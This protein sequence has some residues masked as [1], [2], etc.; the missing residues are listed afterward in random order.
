MNKKLIIFILLAVLFFTMGCAS[1]V[2]TLPTATPGADGVIDVAGTM[3]MAQMNAN[4]AQQAVG[5]S[6]TAT[7]Q[8]IMVTVTAQAREDGLATAEQ[9]RRD[10]AAT[11]AKEQAWAVATDQQHRQDVAATQARIDADATAQQAERNMIGTATAQQQTFYNNMTM[12]VQPTHAIWTQ[13]AVVVAQALATNE[14]ALSNLEVEQ[15]S[16]KNTPEW[17]IPLLIAIAATVAGVFYLVRHS[18]VREIRNPETGVVEAVIF[19]NSQV[20]KPALVTG[21]V[22][23][24]GKV[25]SLPLLAD[26]EV[27]RREQLVQALHAMPTQAPTPMAQGLM[28]GVFGGAPTSR[29]EILAENDAPPAKLVDAH[30]LSSMEQDWKEGQHE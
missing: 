24:V 13:Q 29:F 15:Q 3:A 7:S 5:I 2:D 21:P 12:A 22:L 1:S 20:V 19:N 6:Y 8:V 10:A 11:A 14:V 26:P 4:A 23:T 25:I 9:Q 18:F 17:V 27:M 16:Q 30:A 28:Q